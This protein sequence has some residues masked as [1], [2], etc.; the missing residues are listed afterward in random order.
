MRRSPDFTGASTLIIYSSS[1]WAEKIKAA[2]ILWG[3]ELNQEAGEK[4]AGECPFSM[5]A[6]Q[7]RKECDSATRERG[8]NLLP[9]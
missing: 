5:S 3:E 1:Q 8:S 6:E 2:C 4:C 9:Q 7:E